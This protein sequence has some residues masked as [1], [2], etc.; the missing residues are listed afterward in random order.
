MDTSE[1]EHKIKLVCH[2]AALTNHGGWYL[3]FSINEK[4]ALGAQSHR[5][6][7]SQSSHHLVHRCECFILLRYASIRLVPLHRRVFFD[8]ELA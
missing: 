1:P 3:I 4:N 5:S 7:G 8:A 6:A 2:I